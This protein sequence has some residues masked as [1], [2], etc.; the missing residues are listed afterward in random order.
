[1]N[2]ITNI[3][4][5]LFNAEKRRGRQVE[6]LNRK[7]TDFRAE[8]AA[9]IEADD[10]S[11]QDKVHAKIERVQAEIRAARAAIAA[12]QTRAVN[13]RAAD[14]AEARRKLKAEADA[15]I[16]A[17]WLGTIAFGDAVEKAGAM[18]LQTEP[19]WEEARAK[20]HAAG[21]SDDDLKAMCVPPVKA[22][23]MAF[24]KLIR[25]VHA[26]RMPASPLLLPSVP[27][28]ADMATM[29]ELYQARMVDKPDSVPQPL[30]EG[31]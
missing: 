13:R 12:T 19:L 31:A 25:D 14:D 10:D 11:A 15:A 29:R 22:W 4:T 6:E 28:P 20:G 23:G 27:G 24:K 5:T 2:S 1:M 30:P 17:A 9:A 26:A 16:E 21:L 3:I 18:Y 8:Y 7:L